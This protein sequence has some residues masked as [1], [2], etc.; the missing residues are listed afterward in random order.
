MASF[1]ADSHAVKAKTDP[2]EFE[3]QKWETD[4][5]FRERELKIKEAEGRPKFYQNPVL[6]SAL[7]LVSALLINQ[8]GE[9]VNKFVNARDT[10]RREQL[11]LIEKTL[12]LGRVGL[13]FHGMTVSVERCHGSLPR[14]LDHPA[15]NLA[16]QACRHH[17]ASLPA[18]AYHQEIMR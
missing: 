9:A 16:R 17:R 13:G 5:A 10:A 12:E 3:R 18:A 2:A 6:V 11:A 14:R 15:K 7:G 1:D 4:V 8:V